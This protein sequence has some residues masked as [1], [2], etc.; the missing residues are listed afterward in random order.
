MKKYLLI[1]WKKRWPI[2]PVS[3]MFAVLWVYRSLATLDGKPLDCVSVL[4][5][6]DIVVLLFPFRWGGEHWDEH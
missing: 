6:F 5:C 3:A 4:L 1:R 2:I